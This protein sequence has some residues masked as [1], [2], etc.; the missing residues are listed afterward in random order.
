MKP[1]MRA[2]SVCRNMASWPMFL[3]VLFLFV[4]M[5]P[6]A[7]LA[8]RGARTLQRNLAD[9][10]GDSYTIVAGRVVEVRN[11]PHP[12]YRN[13]HTVVVTLDVADVWKG[14]AGRQFTFRVFVD[15]SLDEQASLGYRVGQQVLLFMTQPSQIGMSS[16]AGLE[17]GRFRIQQDGQGNRVAVNGMSNLG[18]FRN[19][20]QK[21]P[22]LSAQVSE[23]ARRILAQ[24]R[25]GPIPYDTLKEMVL[26][27]VTN[28]Q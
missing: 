12:Q 9:L 22:K 4:V 17:Q 19:V 8:Q 3:L 6:T 7:V 11:E 15:D 1:E 26:A 16:P 25:S 14:M 27:L 23:P 28:S 21:A 13:I 20:T 10:V 2:K 24:H 5:E 18:L